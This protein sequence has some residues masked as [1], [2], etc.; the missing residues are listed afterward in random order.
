M[1]VVEALDAGAMYKKGEV[2][3]SASTTGGQL[4]DKLAE[5]GAN[6]ISDVLINFDNIV[7]EVQDESLVTYA[8]KLD[9]E[10]CK[11]NFNINADVLFSRGS[12]LPKNEK[13]S[14][15]RTAL[16]SGK[17]VIVLVPGHYV[18]FTGTGNRVEL[19][20]PGNS[21]NNGTYTL[22]QL[23]EKFKNHKNLCTTAGKCDFMLAVAYSK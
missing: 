14:K 11:I 22:E 16:N 23:W 9:K 12:G 8:S 7:P 4:H 1:Q 5:I 3:I 10:E 18:V 21:S 6:L 20:D 2:E 15:I 19:L 17:V 13:I